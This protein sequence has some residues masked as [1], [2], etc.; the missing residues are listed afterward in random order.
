V[1]ISGG[2]W[3]QLDCSVGGRSLSS[4]IDTSRA[5]GY[6]SH[7]GLFFL[8]YL[9]KGSAIERCIKISDQIARVPSHGVGYYLLSTAAA[10][11][12]VMEQDERVR[13]NQQA[14]LNYRGVTNHG[15]NGI[16]DGGVTIGKQGGVNIKNP[17]ADELPRF[18]FLEFNAILLDSELQIHCQYS[19]NQYS[20]NTI[21]KLTVLIRKKL[22]EFVFHPS[23]V[24]GFQHEHS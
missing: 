7:R 16:A 8:P 24:K 1:H 12:V 17:F 19:R 11:G 23:P 18:Y 6:L 15:G 22:M 14:C 5:V 3:T 21:D 2:S 10:W 9:G 20:S 13:F 4:G